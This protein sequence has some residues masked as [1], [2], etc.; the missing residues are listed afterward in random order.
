MKQLPYKFLGVQLDPLSISELNSL[1]TESIQR[2]K[3]GL[4]PIITCIAFIFTI[5]TQKCE[6]SMQ[7][8]ITPI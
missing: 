1:V 2:I 3:N 4:L 7:R 6:L 5:T 8:P